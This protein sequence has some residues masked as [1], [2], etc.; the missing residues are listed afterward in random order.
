MSTMGVP[1]VMLCTG[2]LGINRLFFFF[3]KTLVLALKELLVFWG[4][5]AYN[6][7][8]AIDCGKFPNQR[9]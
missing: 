7:M 2:V 4:R 3:F 1:G 6:L 9:W 8:I 5:E